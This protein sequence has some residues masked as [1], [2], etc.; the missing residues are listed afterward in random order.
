MSVAERTL[1]HNLEAERA[2]LGAILLQSDVLSL[3]SGRLAADDFFRR[4]HAQ[5]YA[6]ML[7]LAE[8]AV[9]IDLTTVRDDLTRKGELDK[10]GG[11]AYVSG[12]VD[13][14]PHSTN[15]EYY[16]GIV[17]E[18]AM[19][20]RL[21]FAANKALASAYEGEDEATAILTAVEAEILAVGDRH[22][23]GEL[24]DSARMA[25]E[26]MA[27]LER[28]QET[29]GM[30]GLSTGLHDLDAQTLGLHPGQL[31]V[32]AAR[33]G[34][35]KSA[36]AMQ[37]A[38]HVGLH[39]R[40]TAPVFSLEMAR[41]EL[42]MRILA[43]EGRVNGHLMRAGR[44]P[45]R[46]YPRLGE[47]LG[48]MSEGRLLV[49]DTPARS[50]LQIRSACRRLRARAGELAV[51][52]VDYLQLMTPARRKDQNRE[53]EVAGLAWGCKVLGKE[54]MVPVLLLSQLNRET[55]QRRGQKPQLSDL[56]ESGAIEQ[57]ADNVLF[58]HPPAEANGTCEIIVAKQRNGPLT[59]VQ[60]GYDAAEFRFWD[61]APDQ[62][63]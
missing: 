10:C 23:E 60:V 58:V 22:D 56:R 40:R 48:M 19:L 53:Q 8:R 38:R 51:I 6:A 54:L 17:A 2:V 24:V 28:L 45:E 20:R 57:H 55:E 7:R 27:L 43:A 3:V 26:G 46:S 49:D 37:V 39:L 9:A 50:V 62:A 12:L 32:V 59:S 15:V 30:V 42:I 11:P 14:V 1:P 44:T 47:V 16:G 25:T 13:G 5:I 29:G 61:L 31:T 33:P 4:A 52:V 41:E 21:I 35:G 63:A 34:R 18:K 36:F